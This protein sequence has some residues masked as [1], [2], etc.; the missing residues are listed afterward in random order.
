MRTRGQVD[1]VRT[2]AETLYKTVPSTTEGVE[3]FRAASARGGLMTRRTSG[4][5]A[6]P[7]VLRGAGPAP[8]RRVRAF[9]TTCEG[10]EAFRAASARGGSTTRR[11]SVS[12]A[13]SAVLRG[14]GPAPRRRMRADRTTC[15]GVVGEA[16]P[17]N[18]AARR[19]LKEKETSRRAS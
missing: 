13:R 5:G 18:A 2:D 14:A 7:A 15:E 1:G 16:L 9:R 17:R 19:P 10:V 3:A 4:P 6:R 8:R 12:A 11:T